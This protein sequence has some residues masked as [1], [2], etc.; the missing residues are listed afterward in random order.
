MNMQAAKSHFTCEGILEYIHDM[1]YSLFK[2]GSI[3][4]LNI[5]MVDHSVDT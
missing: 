3:E 4:I 1:R 5:L 2:L